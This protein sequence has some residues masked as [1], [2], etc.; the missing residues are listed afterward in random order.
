LN[1]LCY[2]EH[3]KSLIL[4]ITEK[5]NL[6][7][8]KKYMAELPQL[9]KHFLLIL[10]KSAKPKI[11]YLKKPGIIILLINNDKPPPPTISI[12]LKIF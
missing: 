10:K 1:T 7:Q 9:K 12:I 8:V 3:K 5:I 2:R 6:F 11:G 4:A